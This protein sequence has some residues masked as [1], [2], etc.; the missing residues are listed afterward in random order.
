MSFDAKILVAVQIKIAKI[1]FSF[2][3]NLIFVLIYIYIYNIIMTI[4]FIFLFQ[5]IMVLPLL[6]NPKLGFASRYDW[7]LRK[8]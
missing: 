4:I 2:K 3:G 1:V 5:N 6:R 7:S 8:N